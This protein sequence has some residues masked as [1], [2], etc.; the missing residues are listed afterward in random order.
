MN[1]TNIGSEGSQR[2]YTV[3]P[4]TF[5]PFVVP[6]VNQDYLN[7]SIGTSQQ[8]L[9]VQGIIAN[10]PRLALPTADSFV[11]FMQNVAA[12][13]SLEVLKGWSKSLAEQA[14]LIKEE[15]NSPAY[16]AKQEEKYKIAIGSTDN[17]GITQ[18]ST[19]N[20][21]QQ[22]QNIEPDLNLRQ[23]WLLSLGAL[24]DV[25]I[26]MAQGVSPSGSIT[27][28]QPIAAVGSKDNIAAINLNTAST[29]S[30]NGENTTAGSQNI[31]AE[32]LTKGAVLSA[33]EMIFFQAPIGSAVA[34][35]NGLHNEMNIYHQA[36][37]AVSANSKDPATE[38]AGWFSA[39][40]G[41]GLIYRLSGDK[42]ESLESTK[43]ANKTVQDIDFAKNYAL[44]ALNTIN[45]PAFNLGIQAMLTTAAPEKLK[46]GATNAHLNELMSK[47]KLVV[48]SLSLALLTKLEVGSKENEG[49]INEMEFSG[50]I[51]GDALGRKTDITKPEYDVYKTANIKQLLVDNIK[52]LLKELDPAEENE[53]MYRLNGYMSTNPA[54]EELL[55]QRKAFALVFSPPMGAEERIAESPA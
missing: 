23:K 51:N 18:I 4:S 12:E 21:N 55:D 41:I 52:S 15:I 30:I 42:M 6:G 24:F 5:I 17:Q 39:M 54:V 14:A 48:L 49:W 32:I 22:N 9:E 28:A 36:W 2:S 33:A 10:S 44:K 25:A 45:S 20:S 7:S 31:A 29:V 40:W 37:G 35:Q 8:E 26:Q 1:E 43:T 27:I 50:L 53:V 19:S 3:D 34:L 47:A 11:I 16:I 13:T 38:V 46:D